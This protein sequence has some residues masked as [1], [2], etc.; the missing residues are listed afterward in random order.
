MC[1]KCWSEYGSPATWNANIKRALDL[2]R[3]IYETEC[4]G[5]PL[6]VVLDDWNLE[7]GHIVIYEESLSG[8]DA[9]SAHAAQAA[10]ELVPL[11]L[12]MPVEERAATLAYHGGFIMPPPDAAAEAL[13]KAEADCR[14]LVRLNTEQEEEI[15]RLRARIAE[16][17]QAPKEA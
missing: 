11:F 1:E 3:I 6:H 15:A 16:L 2:V 4:T 7:D 10:K 8:P 17:E 13:F 9:V 5:A 12:A 14:F